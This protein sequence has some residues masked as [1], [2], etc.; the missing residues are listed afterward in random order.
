MLIKK[1]YTIIKKNKQTGLRMKKIKKK[2]KKTKKTV[3][4]KMRKK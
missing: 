3:D 4:E 1:V 2:E